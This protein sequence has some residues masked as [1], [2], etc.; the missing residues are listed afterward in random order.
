MASPAWPVRTT[1]GGQS[2]A[3]HGQGKPLLLLGDGVVFRPVG[4]QGDVPVA[5]AGQVLHR[6]LPA[7][8]VVAQQG[9]VLLR[10]HPAPDE[11][12]GGGAA[13]GLDMGYVAGT[14]SSDEGPHLVAHH[15]PTVPH[16]Q[17]HIAVAAAQHDAV[18]L[19]RRRHAH[20]VEN[21]VVG[22]VVPHGGHHHADGAGALEIEVPGGQVWGV[23]QLLRDFFDPLLGGAGDVRRVP[24]GL[25]HRHVRQSGDLRDGLQGWTVGHPSTSRS[26]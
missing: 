20:L 3:L 2:P 8:V 7:V 17:L 22:G 18:A 12:D 24:Q 4:E 23:A 25:G 1:R 13:G 26:V 6:Q 16:L 10:L 19:L 9:V 21:E 11:D 15:H 5:Q 14:G